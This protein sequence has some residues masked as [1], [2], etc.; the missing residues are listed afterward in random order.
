[1]PEHF[2]V[3][4]RF[5]SQR[6]AMDFFEE[7][8][9]FLHVPPDHGL[10]LQELGDVDPPTEDTRLIVV[11]TPSETHPWVVPP[12]HEAVREEPAP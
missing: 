6:E 1:M 8:R 3:K 9:D 10:R 2:S 5:H 12:L 11:A 7:M 4:F